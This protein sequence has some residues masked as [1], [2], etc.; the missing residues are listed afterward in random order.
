MNF[1]RC[2]E[3]SC[4]AKGSTRV[5]RG[6]VILKG[7]RIYA[8]LSTDLSWGFPHVERGRNGQRLLW[9]GMTQRRIHSDS[10]PTSYLEGNDT[11]WGLH[12]RG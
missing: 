6:T 4:G 1:F 9:V 12:R 10:T 2:S 5:L 11:F 7:P 3:L 8:D